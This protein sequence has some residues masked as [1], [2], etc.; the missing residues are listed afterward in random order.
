MIKH[1]S[2]AIVSEG[3]AR[4][5]CNRRLESLLFVV[6]GKLCNQLATVS[7]ISIGLSICRLSNGLCVGVCVFVFLL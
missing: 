7:N 2:I 4:S 6:Q 1:Q 3:F 5:N